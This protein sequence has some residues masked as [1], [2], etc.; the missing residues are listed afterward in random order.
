MVLGAV[1]VERERYVDEEK[2]LGGTQPNG[3]SRFFAQL[4]LDMGVCA[5]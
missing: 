2:V 5:R 3:H 1:V 4:V